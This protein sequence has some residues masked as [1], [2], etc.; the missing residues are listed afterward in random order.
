MSKC[1]ECGHRE[2]HQDPDH[3][4]CVAQVEKG[5]R[6]TRCG[7]T[8]LVI[9]NERAIATR[10]PERI[11]AKREPVAKA[12]RSTAKKSPTRRVATKR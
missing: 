9:K 4:G 3:G 11:H 8:E 6:V 2:V 7:C 10:T 5:Q 1:A 12:T